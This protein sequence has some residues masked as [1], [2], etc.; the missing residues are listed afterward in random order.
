MRVARLSVATFAR[1]SANA[2]RCGILFDSGL[3]P[4]EVRF[5]VEVPGHSPT[6]WRT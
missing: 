6:F 2:K 3:P 1:R 4:G 5:E